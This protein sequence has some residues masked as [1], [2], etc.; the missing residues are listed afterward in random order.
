MHEVCKQ[1]TCGGGEGLFSNLAALSEWAPFPQLVG[2]PAGG[3][4][5]GGPKHKKREGSGRVER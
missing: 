3:G 4:Q 2:L 5:G 1:N